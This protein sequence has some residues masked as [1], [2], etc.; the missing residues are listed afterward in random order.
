VGEAMAK[1]EAVA[2]GGVR[3]GFVSLGGVGGGVSLSMSSSVTPESCIARSTGYPRDSRKE[4]SRSLF[5]DC[6][7]NRSEPGAM[8]ARAMPPGAFFKSHL[9]SSQPPVRLP[10]G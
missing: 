6:V 2:L 3:G 5:S 1:R 9:S 7:S 10:Y 8:A 4:N